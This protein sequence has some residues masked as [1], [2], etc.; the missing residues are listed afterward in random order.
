MIPKSAVRAFLKQPRDDHRPYKKLKFKQLR[1]L[2]SKLPIEPPLWD[3][4]RKHQRVGF[5]LGAKHKRF[6]FFY[7]TGT[8]KTILSI[9]IVRYLSKLKQ[10]KC[11]I[12]LVPNNINCHEWVDEITK[13][14]P[15][16]TCVVLEGSTADKWALLENHKA[17]FFICT[18]SGFSLMAC[19]KVDEIKKKKKT[20]K[21]KF[22]P[23]AKLVKQLCKKFDGVIADESTF[24]GN[25]RTLPYRICRQLTKDPDVALFE[26]TGTPF[27]RDP[28]PLW[29]QMYL[30][31]KGESLGKTL[32]IFRATFFDQKK[33][34]W[35]GFEYKYKKEMTPTLN[36]LLAHRSI[37]YEA[38][39]ADL[40]AVIP[41]KIEVNLPQ[42]AEAYYA[43]AK[44]QLQ[45]AHGNF[46]EMKNSFLRMRQISSGF[47]GYYDDESGEKAKF[48]FDENPKLD[49]LI[50][51]VNSIR[52]DKKILIFH[53]FTHSGD[54]IAKALKEHKI[55]FSRIY[56]KNSKTAKMQL[57]RFKTDP[58]V[59]VFL[60]QNAAGSY[61]LNLQMAQYLLI[62]ESTVRPILRKQ[63]EARVKRYG[64]KHKKIFVY[65]FVV[66]GTYDQRILKFLKEG[67]D[68]F[69]SIMKNAKKKKKK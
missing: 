24:L 18:Y 43:K 60:L 10:N 20:G 68:L 59:R 64:S 3:G 6:A 50:D 2:K 62:Y 40:P 53:E 19:T 12:V 36:R 37:Q 35:G 42:D 15:S 51:L 47:V 22:K 13:H 5:L 57:K 32:G 17:R 69:E 16:S 54:L 23:D 61:G 48:S 26:L 34:Y 67:K 11:Y 45:Q 31:D 21:K 52:A 39:E 27:G 30:V 33:N 29:S 4:L 14:S 65:D 58:E 8:G 46:Q 56:G 49:S 1:K 25:H 66:R 41:L 55:K 28:T 63:I 38:D 7:D 44:K 9:S